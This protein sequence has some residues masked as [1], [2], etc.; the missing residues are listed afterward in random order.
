MKDIFKVPIQVHDLNVDNDKIIKWSYDLKK[1]DPGRQISNRGGWQSNGL[2]DT[3]E[4]DELTRQVAKLGYEYGKGIGL[5]CSSIHFGGWVNINEYL[6]Y[7][8]SH[9]HNGALFS[10]VYYAQVPENSGDIVFTNPL[11]EKFY[12]DT[13]WDNFIDIHNEYTSTEYSFTPKEK[14]L[15]IIPGWLEHYVE[16]N[17]NENEERISIAFNGEFNNVV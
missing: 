12:N 2:T 6:S 11:A 14:M 17:M 8:K 13:Y 15:L 1:I 16:K 9:T 4:I 5:N 10:C 7:N 3:S